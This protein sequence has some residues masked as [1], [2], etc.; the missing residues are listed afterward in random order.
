LLHILKDAD[1]S[2][3]LND[4]IYF[5]LF[6]SYYYFLFYFVIIIII[7]RIYYA[8]AKAKTPQAPQP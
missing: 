3:G 1:I 6:V 4:I 5:W 7:K 8:G 2:I